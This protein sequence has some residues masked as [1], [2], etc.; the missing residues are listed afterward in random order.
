[1]TPAPRFSTSS[2]TRA[3]LRDYLVYGIYPNKTIVRK[4]PEDNLIDARN[5]DSPYVIFGIF[6]D[7]RLV[8]KFPNGTI[9]PDPPRRPV[10]VVFTLST[11]TT[12]NR[13]PPRPYYNQANQGTYN[14]YR[15][16]VYD[17]NGRPVAE[18]TRN[19]QTPGTIDARLSG[20]AIV[21]PNGG[22]P[23][24]TGPLGTPASLP[25]INETVSLNLLFIIIDR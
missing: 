25:S 11:S 17:N 4:R 6:P 18:T 2:S 12:T 1:M 5:V 20:N 10:E 9:I 15:G 13:P 19:A 14:Q 3:P 21:G 16:P 23:D 7:G 24:N 8:R 22:G